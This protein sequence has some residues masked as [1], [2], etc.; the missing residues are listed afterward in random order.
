MYIKIEWGMGGG[1]ANA[2]KYGLLRADRLLARFLAHSF[3]FVFRCHI[4]SRAILVV[5]G[6]LKAD[7]RNGS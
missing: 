2:C 6:A 7:Q 4:F 3:C 1:V 5:L